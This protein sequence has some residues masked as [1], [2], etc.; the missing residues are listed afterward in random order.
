MLCAVDPSDE[1][2][3]AFWTSFLNSC[4]QFFSWVCSSGG[5]QSDSFCITAFWIF[6]ACYSYTLSCGWNLRFLI[7]CWFSNLPFGLRNLSISEL[8]QQAV[9]IFDFRAKLFFMLMQSLCEPASFQPVCY[10]TLLQL[11]CCQLVL[12]II[13]SDMGLPPIPLVKQA[14]WLGFS[15]FFTLSA[16]W[17]K[18]LCFRL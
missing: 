9:S 1:S 16:D 8:L 12:Q 17:S 3:S 7:H 13:I 2:F 15:A 11:F 10:R 6:S 4:Y 18:S 14:Y 5:R